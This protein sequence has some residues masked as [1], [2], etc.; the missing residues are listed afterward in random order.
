MR[1]ESLAF[2]DVPGQTKLFLDYQSNPS[3]LKKFYPNAVES[4]TE[5]TTRIPEVLAAY[6]TDRDELCNALSDLNKSYNASAKALANID[7]LRDKDSVAIVTGQQAGLLSGPLYTIYKALSAVRMAECLRNRGIKAVP[8]FW[9]ATEDHDFEEVA[10]VFFLGT[11]GELVDI[12]VSDDSASTEMP[13][14]MI[15]I[16]NSFKELFDRFFTKL[17]QTEFSSKVREAMQN[18]W[19]PG[20]NFG[21][22]F[23]RFLA[24]VLRD[25]GVIM[26][27][28]LDDRLKQLAAPIYAEAVEKSDE[29]VTSLISRG[30]ELEAE[31]Y[32]AQVMVTEDYFPL[33]WHTD[34]GRRKALKRTSKGNFRVSGEKIE[35][36]VDKLAQIAK[37]EPNRISPGVMLRPA[38]QDYLFPTVCYFGGA[39]E[40]AYFA[41]N[42]EAYR[43]L[44]RP[45]TTILHRQS[46]TI[47]EAKHARTMEKYDLEFRD[48]FDGIDK[49]LPKIVRRFVDPGNS[50]LLADAEEEINAELH[51]L[52]QAFS[53]IDATLAENLATRRRKILYHIAALQQKFVKARIRKDETVNRQITNAFT[54]LLTRGHLQER[55]LNVNTFLNRYGQYFIDWIYDSIDLDD[56]G[57]RVI[58]L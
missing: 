25:Y 57:H 32:H 45:V 34:A 12:K 49:L 44:D 4:H 9:A 29:I 33:F 22:A 41:Q 27:D 23:C 46:F 42:S 40:I 54:A 26:V 15:E 35:F 18:A 8:V 17:P 13:V 1:V 53:N 37:T 38:V 7:L 50:R 14:G 10:A 5:I 47:V 55:T 20:T 11:A 43:I 30:R 51:K 2:A 52:D 19:Q 58:Y 39:A 36:T 48:L 6:K 3:S 21:E 28:P 16:D 24:G 56:K 31:G